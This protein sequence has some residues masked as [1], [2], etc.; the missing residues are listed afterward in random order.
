M[1]LSKNTILNQATCCHSA[2]TGF[3]LKSRSSVYHSSKKLYPASL[4]LRYILI[5]LLFS[6]STSAYAIQPAFIKGTVF[7]T[8]SSS[9]VNGATIST[10]NGV[11]AA[12][13]NG[14]YVLRVP[15]SIYTIIA[16]APDSTANLL[17]GIP[18][19]PGNIAVVNLGITSSSTPVGYVEG[20]IVRSSN[21]EGL[22]GALITTDLG[23]AAISSGSDGS[24]R[25]Q[26]PSGR[27]NLVISA[28]GFSSKQI[29]N[30]PVYAYITTNLSVGL[31]TAP[32]AQIAVKGTI[33]DACT[34]IRIDNAVI[35]SNSGD[36]STSSDGFYSIDTPLGISTLI[37]S[38]DGYQFSSQTFFLGPFSTKPYDFSLFPTANGAGLIRG[39]ITDSITGAPIAGARLE[40]DVG[41]ISSSS[42]NG[43][44]KLYASVCTTALYIS[45]D[46]YVPSVKPVSV[47]KGSATA[48]NFSMVPLATI[49]GTIRDNLLGYA[50]KGAM[51]TLKE[52]PAVSATSS[53]D[54][55]Y[56]L[57]DIAPGTYTLSV[58]HPCYL[59]TAQQDIVVSGNGAIE[60]DVFMEAS[61]YGTVHGAVVN[62]FT[63]KPLSFA[64]VSTSYGARTETGADGL[65]ALELPVCSTDIIIAAPGYLSVK[66]KNITP[67][68]DSSLELNAILVPWPFHFLMNP[69]YGLHEDYHDQS[70]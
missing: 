40:G 46:G 15:P 34:G 64:A 24:F 4:F 20:H 44:Y 51:V 3:L 9:L 43:T 69:E 58:S 12:A 33:K 27:A 37:V 31:N 6:I 59:S 2:D 19:T 45:R 39:L 62:I 56:I 63:G 70:Q 38:A 55:S 49:T 61:A 48:L 23:G 5:S 13:S 52:N 35:L 54:G 57:N 28:D 22:Q 50:V 29:K 32:A 18:A 67:P 68:S 16:T 14:A 42:S 10:A 36:I 30:Y 53:S 11:S 41:G 60:K 26:S 17:S 25:L 66:R 1:K 47:I 7:N 21:G 65:Y 8:F